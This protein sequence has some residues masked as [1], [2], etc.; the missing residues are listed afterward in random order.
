MK[1]LNEMYALKGKTS[2]EASPIM[3][4]LIVIATITIVM[5]CA[6]QSGMVREVNAEDQNLSKVQPVPFSDS[7]VWIRSFEH[8]SISS[9][10]SV[11]VAGTAE[12]AGGTMIERSQSEV[13]PGFVIRIVEDSHIF[14]AV[15]PTLATGIK[16]DYILEGSVRADRFMPW[17]TWAQLADLWLHAFVFRPLASFYGRSGH[18]AVRCETAVGRLMDNSV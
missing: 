10:S 8:R 17:W 4:S 15:T 13:V 7:T 11:Y 3:R 18:Q 12:I 1:I 2:G 16:P 14:R 6:F 5:G 9:V